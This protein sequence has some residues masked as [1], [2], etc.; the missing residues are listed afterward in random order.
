MSYAL[1]VVQQQRDLV[2]QG[3]QRV[4]RVTG[5]AMTATP[6]AARPRPGQA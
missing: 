5:V 2:R 1:T 6:M 3:H 4:N